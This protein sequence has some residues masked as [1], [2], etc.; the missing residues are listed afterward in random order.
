MKRKFTV[1]AT[2][3]ILLATACRKEKFHSGPTLLSFHNSFDY[4]LDTLSFDTVFTLEP[5]TNNPISVTEQFWVKNKEKHTVKASFLL[6]GGKS[7]P[8]RFS[9]DGHAGPELHDIEIP[10]G[11]SVWGFVQCS[12]KPNNLTMPALVLD[13]IIA[14]VGGTSQKLLLQA[15]GW[16]AHYHRS[17]ELPCGGSWTD[18]TK[19][20]F[21]VNSVLVGPGCTFTIG[22]GV[23]I[24]NSPRSTFFVQGTLKINGTPSERVIIEGN[25]HQAWV[26]DQPNQWVGIHFLVGSDKNEIKY[27]DIRNATVGLRCDSLPGSNN[28][29]LNIENTS[30]MWCGQAALIGVTAK[31]DA[32]NCLFAHAGS[33]T[34]LGLLG[35][36]YNFSYCT[37]ATYPDFGVSRDKGHFIITNTL[38]DENGK[39]LQTE[40]LACKNYNSIIYGNLEDEVFMDNSA[41]ASFSAD[42][43]GNLIKSKA[44]PFPLN[45]YNEYPKFKKVEDGDFRLDSLSPAINKANQSL[46]KVG[47]D[48][49]G[50]SRDIDPDIGALE[51]L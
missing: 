38:R 15:Y 19:P 1:L 17:E 9:I 45:T 35:G 21:I 10:G 51:K 34:F 18:K 47:I 23:H 32:T 43:R 8:F 37:F 42:F 28:L 2:L 5:G 6:A 33:Y 39:I 26:K 11:D 12:L 49:L 3:V 16:D 13:S 40:D 25:K 20:Y 14:S 4:S 31:I 44:K 24:F 7:S 29:N 36:T 50:N 27:T 30:V 41:L 48:L 22:E 46:P